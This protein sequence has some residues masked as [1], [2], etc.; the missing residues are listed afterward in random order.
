ML[1]RTMAFGIAVL[2]ASSVW[3][4]EPVFPPGS[5]IGLVPPPGMSVSRTFPGFEDREQRAAIILIERPGNAYSEIDKEFSAEALRTQGIDVESRRE[6]HLDGGSGFIITAQ[7]QF[8]GVPTRKW[9]L[10]AGEEN[11]TA[12]VSIQM[13]AAAAQAYPEAALSASLATVATRPAVPLQE[14][15]DLLPFKI[16]DLAGFHLSNA[17]AAGAALLTEGPAEKIEAG[18]PML[19]ITVAAENALLDEREREALARRA[20]SVVPGLKEMRL[21]R[22]EPL[23]INGRPGYEILLSAKDG[24]SG[25]DLKLVQWLRFGSGGYLRILGAVRTDQWAEVFPRF[26]AVRDGIELR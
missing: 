19:L 23:R 8:A 10:V 20:I 15:L 21:Q 26:R 1:A 11:L 14:Q 22:S 18:Q 7:Q 12:I 3:A 13:P 6:I 9:V 25:T 17:S 5:R 2:T 4:A 24:Q 16:D